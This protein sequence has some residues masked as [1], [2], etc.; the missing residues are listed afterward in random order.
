MSKARQPRNSGRRHSDKFD[1][2]LKKLTVWCLAAIAAMGTIYFS[3]IGMYMTAD[4]KWQEMKAR[5]SP[6]MVKLMDAK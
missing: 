2:W 4:D 1:V 3:A 5:H 6:A